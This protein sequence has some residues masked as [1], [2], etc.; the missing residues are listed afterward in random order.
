MPETQVTITNRALQAMGAR[1][2]IAS[3]GENSKEAKAAALVF[4]D[5]VNEVLE[6]YPW[7]FAQRWINGTPIRRYT[8]AVPPQDGW[9]Y[10]YNYPADALKIRSVSPPPATAT[11]GIPIFGLTL[12]QQLVKPPVSAPYSV[13][14]DDVGNGH[15][16]VVF[17]NLS[18][19]QIFYTKRVVD[20]DTWEP[21]AF[22]LLYL[23][24]A[25]K[26]VAPLAGSKEY[27]AAVS[28]QLAEA[29]QVAMVSD[30][31]ETVTRQ[32]VSTDWLEARY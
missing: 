14:A 9:L 1:A 23:T 30:A 24:L 4:L 21:N 12:D 10:E 11:G 28:N 26:L 29:R 18:A 6:A 17:T 5:A 3:V 31:N 27:M 8:D 25:L 2:Q 7:N 16:R 15:I 13:G 32:D 20:Y 19:A 22:R